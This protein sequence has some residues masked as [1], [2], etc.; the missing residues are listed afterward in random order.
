MMELWRSK[1]GEVGG[2][3]GKS[4]EGMVGG[5]ELVK[6]QVT[7]HPLFGALWRRRKGGKKEKN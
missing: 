5:N 1:G 2:T 7:R 6:L 3:C 4:L